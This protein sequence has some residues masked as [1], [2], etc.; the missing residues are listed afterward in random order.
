MLTDTG[1]LGVMQVDVAAMRLRDSVLSSAEQEGLTHQAYWLSTTLA[2]GAFLKVSSCQA[3]LLLN[4]SGAVSW[5][6]LPGV[7]HSPDSDLS[8]V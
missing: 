8:V 6:A 5:A 3:L 1:T 4:A 7:C 2:L